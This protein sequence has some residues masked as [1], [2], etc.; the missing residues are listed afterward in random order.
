[1]EL[2]GLLSRRTRRIRKPIQCDGCGRSFPV[3][4][5]VHLIK[6]VFDGAFCV[7]DLCLRCLDIA[8]EWEEPDPPLMLPPE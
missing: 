6:Q 7:T 5:E 1:M 2:Q 4:T 8:E 3:G